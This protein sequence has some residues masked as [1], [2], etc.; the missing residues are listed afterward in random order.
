M[1]HVITVGEK[2]YELI[3][4]GRDQAEQLVSFGRW[5]GKHVFPMF[6]SISNPDGTVPEMN[7]QDIFK[8]IFE[9]LDVD[10]VMELFILLV[11][12]TRKEAD[13]HFEIG[14]LFDS[15]TVVWENQPGLR[16][17][18]ERFFSTPA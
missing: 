3:K 5:L 10:A 15:L 4:T 2:E 1:A 11:G 13:K 17:T 12:C 18:L 7:Y 8:L 14:V 16:R 9:G 6:S